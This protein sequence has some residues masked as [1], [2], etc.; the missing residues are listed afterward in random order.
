[1][2]VLLNLFD[3][4]TVLGAILGASLL[5]SAFT[6]EMS[7]IQEGAAA[8]MAVACAAIPYCLAATL[9]RALDRSR[10]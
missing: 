3:A 4:I 1:M 9:H 8:A 5:Y 2:R 6:S 7:A 10:D